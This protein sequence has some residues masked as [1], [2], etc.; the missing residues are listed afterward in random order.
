MKPPRILATTFL[1]TLPAFAVIETWDG[2]GTD[3]NLS[4][5]L[6]W[7]DNSA[8]VSDLVNTDLVF[9]GVVR[10]TPFVSAAL[11]ADS[12]TF[13]NTAGAFTIG[14]SMLTLGSGGIANSD[15]D[16][17][18][19]GSPISFG[20]VATSSILATTG[21]LT[22]TNTITLPTATLTVDGPGA[23]SFRNF[24]GTKTLTKQG[25]GTMTWRPSVANNLDLVV[26][27]GT[28]NTGA[29]G[30]LDT[31]GSGGSIAV[32]GTSAFNIGESLTLDSSVITRTSFASLTL[33]AGKTLS[34]QNGGDVT[35]TGGFNQAT[36][37]TIHVTGAGST[38]TMSAGSDFRGGSTL[39]ITAGGSVA[40][41]SW[42]DLAMGGGN[43]TVVVD[44]A[45]SSFAAGI[46]S[47][48]GRSGNAA[49]VTFSNGSGGNF[50]D[51]QLANSGVGSAG[52][53]NVQSSS[54]L[55]TGS[56]FL[57]NT[58]DTTTAAMTV[59]GASSL[60]TQTGGSPMTIGAASA[61]TASLTVING[62]TFT[63]GTGLTTVNATG[64]LAIATGIFKEARIC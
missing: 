54:T 30:T 48:W 33:A 24:S 7:L 18:T 9:A 5:A 31:L 57:A 39:N 51:I 26:S 25:A 4:T 61:S 15:T 35:I 42:I 52:T 44:G 13:N 28:L 3:S 22:F 17:Q 63:S 46:D 12:V 50:G 2:G 23:T 36:A 64:S 40:S 43:A 6:N 1:L 16:S 56:L 11:S 38:F 29:D 10:L 19:F 37:A 60:I 58:T 21:G 34:V 27:A 8:P 32:N 45:G 59:D 20:S 41:A 53:V 55:T 14:G 47:L 49:A 62:G